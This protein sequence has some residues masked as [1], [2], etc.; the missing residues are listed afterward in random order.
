MQA[1]G[2]RTAEEMA[3]REGKYSGVSCQHGLEQ[4]GTGSLAPNNEK[5]SGHL[6]HV[7]HVN[8]SLLGHGSL[9]CQELF[10]IR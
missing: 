10:T 4:G 3:F 7:L 9:G 2:S 8:F 5:P 6:I 1:M